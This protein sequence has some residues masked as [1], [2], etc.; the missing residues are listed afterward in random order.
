MSTIAGADGCKGGWLCLTENTDAVITGFIALDF[1]SLINSLSP[2][3]ILAIDIPIGLPEIGARKCDIEAR[4]RLGRPRGSSVFP[5]PIRAVLNASDYQVA[6]AIGQAH[7]GKK[8]SRQTFEIIPKIREV[9]ALLNHTTMNCEVRECHPEV[10]FAH[11]AGSPMRF[12]KKTVD[13]R[14]ERARLVDNFWSAERIKVMSQL[15]RG[16]FAVDDLHDA[17]AALWTARRLQRRQAVVL[18]EAPEIDSRGL[19]MEIVV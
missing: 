4:R 8:I 6:C 2:S 17:F 7:E 12:R 10:S 16:K 9:D 15:P 5:A 13:G 19:R 1:P 3:T 18:P 14:T 11:W